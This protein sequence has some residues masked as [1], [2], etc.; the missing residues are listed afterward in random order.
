MWHSLL[1][2]LSFQVFLVFS[3]VA[4]FSGPHA[5][6]WGSVPM[7]DLPCY[8]RQAAEA[9][10]ASLPPRGSQQCCGTSDASQGLCQCSLARCQAIVPYWPC[11]VS[12]PRCPFT[13]DSSTTSP[14]RCFQDYITS[15]TQGYQEAPVNGTFIL[16]KQTPTVLVVFFFSSG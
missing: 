3:H 2:V 1:E 11:G 14:Q 10:C 13:E 6:F 8:L 9:K 16:V 12:L 5:A 7:A 15:D 4:F